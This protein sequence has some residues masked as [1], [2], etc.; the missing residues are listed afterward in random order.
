M[1]LLKDY[2]S[3]MGLTKRQFTALVGAGYALGHSAD[4][5]GLFCQ[6]NSF[7]NWRSHPPPRLSN[8]FFSDLLSHQW[9]P[10]STGGRKMFQV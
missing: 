3:V 1:E 10:V 4:C 6:R 7:S 8:I 9:K 2:I 5:D